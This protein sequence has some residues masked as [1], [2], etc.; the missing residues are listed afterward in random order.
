MTVVAEEMRGRGEMVASWSVRF[1]WMDTRIAS[2][3]VVVQG[4]ESVLVWSAQSVDDVSTRLAR[5]VHDARWAFRRRQCT[6]RSVY[7]DK[8]SKVGAQ[9]AETARGG[10][11][12]T[13][14]GAGRRGR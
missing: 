2:Q 6:R 3:G 10:R 8:A 12:R 1:G 5:G 11:R 14:G 9:R 13:P 7:E 4:R